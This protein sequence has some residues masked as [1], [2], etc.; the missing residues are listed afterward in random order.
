MYGSPQQVALH[1]REAEHLM[2]K[3]SRNM[4]NPEK[5][6]QVIDSAS[7][8]L[9]V[10]CTNA[11]THLLQAIAQEMMHSRVEQ[12]RAKEALENVIGQ[13]GKLTHMAKLI[14]RVTTAILLSLHLDP[15]DYHCAQSYL[16]ALGLNLKEKSSGRY[17]GQLKI[18]KRGSGK[19]RQ[20]LYF[21]AL[22]LIQS[23]PTAKQ[24]Y[25]NKKTPKAKNKAVIAVMRKLA[26]G[27]WHV[28]R[29]EAYAPTK[30]FNVSGKAA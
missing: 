13:E 14:G 7:T 1:K 4:L 19:A 16:K 26:G 11:E 27:L 25:E 29:G 9:G 23:C 24:W 17:V 10:P 3:V 8:T 21:A 22:R 30:L 20:Y 18:T 5:I 6:R 28:A 15:R 12:K 2:K